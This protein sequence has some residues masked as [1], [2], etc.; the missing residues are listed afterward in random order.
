MR[1][2]L[3]KNLLHLSKR[4]ALLLK[5]SVI[6]C[7]DRKHMDFCVTYKKRNF[8]PKREL[9][10]RMHLHI[11]RTIT[12]KI[13]LTL[14]EFTEG[15]VPVRTSTSSST[16]AINCRKVSHVDVPWPFGTTCPVWLLV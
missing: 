7:S 15:P 9:A 13:P 6:A 16:V 8:N 2:Q 3:E 4:I 12:C 11:L 5:T 14:H 10:D 1:A